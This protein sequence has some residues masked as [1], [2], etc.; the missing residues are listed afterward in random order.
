MILSTYER[1]DSPWVFIQYQFPGQK[2]KANRT[3]IRKDD[4]QKK[5]KIA[6]AIAHRRVELLTAEPSILETGRGVESWAW[7]AGYLLTRYGKAS[8]TVEVYRHQW[9]ALCRYLSEEKI[10]S[11]AMLRRE[12]CAPGYVQWRTAQ[13]KE[14]SGKNPS[15]NTAIG[16]LKLLALLMD[17]A[18]ARGLAEVNPCR[19]L[20]I[21]RVEAKEKP[22]ISDDEAA[23][24]YA[25]LQ[26]R[27]PWMYRSFHMALQT[28][29][30][31]SET[32]ILRSQVKLADGL[33]QIETPKGG[34]AKAFSIPIYPAIREM[35]QEF[36]D[37]G[38]AA[39]WDMPAKERPFASLFWSRFFKEK[40]LPH[41][42]FHCTRVTFIT[43]G[44]RAGVP[45]GA[46]MAMVNHASTDIHRI[47]RRFR[48]ADAMKYFAQMQLPAPPA[49]GATG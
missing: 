47:Y 22:E 30:R 32:R 42:C 21:G 14:K 5:K 25:A 6:I 48:G 7:V 40:R 39:L 1:A 27:K 8:R 18:V 4:P 37:S 24:I 12:H 13:V 46:M 29:L 38:E 35:V 31:F 28:G 20:K 23:K 34:R 36:W 26:T 43:R 9:G 41:L 3:K 17:E 33:L 16:E 10:L 11:P 15:V 19:K 49:A 44:A 2:K 45:E